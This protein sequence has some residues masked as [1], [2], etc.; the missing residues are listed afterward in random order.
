MDDLPHDPH[1][2][3][4]GFFVENEDAAMGVVKFPRSSVRINGAQ[5]PISMPPRLGEHTQALLREAG[6]DEARI[7]ALQSNDS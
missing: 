6:W 2:Q 1:L 5:P 4:T 7:A 3:A